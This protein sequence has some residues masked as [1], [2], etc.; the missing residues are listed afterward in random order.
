MTVDYR[1]KC[2][3]MTLNAVMA[4]WNLGSNWLGTLCDT[5]IIES[6]LLCIVHTHAARRMPDCSQRIESPKRK[7]SN[8][9][10]KDYPC[11]VCWSW[12]LVESATKQGPNVE[13]NLSS[14]WRESWSNSLWFLCYGDSGPC[15]SRWTEVVEWSTCS[16]SH[17]QSIGD[18]VTGTHQH[19][20][21]RSTY[22]DLIILLSNGS[23]NYPKWYIGQQRVYTSSKWTTPVHWVWSREW[24]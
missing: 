1:S 15:W 10:P 7:T 18:S 23:R 3:N 19:Y 9:P 20:S 5:R 16:L 14:S 13:R 12:A 22:I 4:C 11:R 21:K 8:P 6:G 17:H 24:Q 2:T